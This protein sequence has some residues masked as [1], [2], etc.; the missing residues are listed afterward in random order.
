MPDRGD[1]WSDGLIVLI[2]RLI[3]RM[4]IQSSW[5]TGLS[6]VWVGFVGCVNELRVLIRSLS[7][8]CVFGKL[9]VKAVCCIVWRLGIESHRHAEKK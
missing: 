1:G 2:D 6:L 8:G 4:V 3:R 5:K 7:C 9:A